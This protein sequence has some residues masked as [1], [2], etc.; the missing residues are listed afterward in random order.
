MVGS[1]ALRDSLSSSASLATISSS[2]CLRS[3][4]SDTH[5]T[6]RRPTSLPPSR[7]L[8]RLEVRPGLT[9]D[10]DV[11]AALEWLL[12]WSKPVKHS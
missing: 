11:L 9:T 3:A 10:G 8:G 6:R 5:D 2:I 1:A 12:V 7:R 4:L